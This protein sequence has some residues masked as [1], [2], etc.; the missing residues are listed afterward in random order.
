MHKL[1]T[2][3]P[4]HVEILLWHVFISK[5]LKRNLGAVVIVVVY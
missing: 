3:K 1:L 2:Y 5:S 4:S